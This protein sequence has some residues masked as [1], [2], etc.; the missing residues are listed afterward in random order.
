MLIYAILEFIQLY[1]QVGYIFNFLLRLYLKCLEWPMNVQIDCFC[2]LASRNYSNRRRCICS[3]FKPSD[4]SSFGVACI[5]LAF[6]FH[7]R[8]MIFLLLGCWSWKYWLAISKIQFNMVKHW[9]VL[10]LSL[11]VCS[12]DCKRSYY[13][14][15]YLC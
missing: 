8:A 13:T 7:S 3:F 1:N 10:V 6:L 12:S 2:K 11:N 5:S 4:I 15:L 9:N 14:S